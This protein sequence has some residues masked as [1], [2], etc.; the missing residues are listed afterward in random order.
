[1][2]T[3]YYVKRELYGIVLRQYDVLCTYHSTQYTRCCESPR[4]PTALLSIFPLNHFDAPTMEN[5][6][7]NFASVLSLY[8]L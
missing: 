8:L 7:A 4:I 6:G 3:V 5:A 2:H 1:M